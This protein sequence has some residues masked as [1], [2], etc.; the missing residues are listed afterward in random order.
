MALT[1]KAT[2][3]AT[4]KEVEV[5]KS[6]QRETYIDYADCSTEYK[7]EELKFKN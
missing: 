4:G 5:Y 1:F 7:K 6:S 2:V 3:V